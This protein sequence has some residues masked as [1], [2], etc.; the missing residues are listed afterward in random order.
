VNRFRKHLDKKG[1]K[2][3]GITAILVIG[4]ILT[5]G[6][7]AMELS[8]SNFP[9]GEVNDDT[10]VDYTVEMEMNEDD[11]F[12]PVEGVN[13]TIGEN[14]ASVDL[15]D[16]SSD[17]FL[18]VR[19]VE[20][21][22]VN[23]GFGYG[24]GY[25]YDADVGGNNGFGYGYG[26]GTGYGYGYGDNA[27]A[28]TIEAN[29]TIDT[30]DL[31]LDTG[32]NYNVNT[33][34]FTGG[35]NPNEYQSSDTLEI[36]S[37]SSSSDGDD[38]TGGG[39]GSF[40][41]GDEE[42]D[43]ASQPEPKEVEAELDPETETATAQVED[44]QENQE[45]EVEVPE[46]EQG[47][48]APVES[49]SFTSETEADSAEVS[50][51][52]LGSDS[53]DSVEEQVGGTVYSYQ[54]INVEGVEDEDI[55]TASIGFQVEKSFLEQNDREPEDVVME[56]YN[57]DSWEQL[58]TRL[59]E[60]LNNSF[61]FE[62]SST[63]FSFYAIALQEDEEQED[64]QTDT[65]TGTDTPGDTGDGN[66]TDT[67]GDDE[68]QSGPPVVP[69]VAALVLALLVGVGYMNRETLQQKIEELQEK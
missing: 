6:S 18:S 55:S 11:E 2:S 15:S 63:G 62:A 35:D 28:R 4:L 42:G 53:P 37:T 10:E 24:Y 23:D 34:A 1:V 49:V 46:P 39:G 9:G 29:L 59:D 17:D 65:G 5:T 57:G 26:Y 13:V 31:N 7:A 54:E 3:G 32:E 64:Q 19:N 27:E 66:Q 68:E 33:E 45:V 14:E 30:E 22:E 51:S 48:P 43:Q 60:E 12:I 16:S 69:I 36:A 20:F 50:V 58:D 56:R 40:D 61:R 52:D 44:V 67:D 21:N 8:T 25:G 38:D 47:E 41:T